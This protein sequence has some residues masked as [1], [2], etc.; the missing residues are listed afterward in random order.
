MP[1]VNFFDKWE[2]KDGP[3]ILQWLNF[4]RC[5]GQR[6]QKIEP[7]HNQIG[8]AKNNYYKLK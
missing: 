5:T 2:K 7:D 1:I 8:T 4:T 6:K 3:T